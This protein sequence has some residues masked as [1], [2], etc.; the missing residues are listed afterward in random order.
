MPAIDAQPAAA[1]PLQQD[2]LELVI[3]MVRGEQ[4]LARLQPGG[5]RG[6]ARLA[7]GG[8]GTLRP[9]ARD[10]VTR[11]SIEGNDRG[12]GQPR[13]RPRAQ[14]AESACNP[15]STWMRPQAAA[16]NVPARCQL[17]QRH[18]QDR[19]VEAAAQRDAETWSGSWP[20]PARQSSSE[21]EAGWQ[22][23]VS[24]NTSCGPGRR[25]RRGQLAAR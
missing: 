14:R 12:R 8:L 3:G 10:H 17:R 16:C 24:E 25:A 20:P 22:V 9:A 15:W 6:I 19:G 23:A 4:D 13:R 18:Q 5:E 7:R 2:R 11:T 1:Q 21:I